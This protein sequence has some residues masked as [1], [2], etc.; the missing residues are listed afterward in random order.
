MLQ[1]ISLDRN[2]SLAELSCWNWGVT[3]LSLD[4]YLEV[5][6]QYKEFKCHI[7]CLGRIE[8]WVK[9]PKEHTISTKK[10][11]I[12]NTLLWGN[13][14]ATVNHSTKLIWLFSFFSFYTGQRPEKVIRGSNQL[15]KQLKGPSCPFL[16]GD[17]IS[18]SQCPNRPFV[19]MNK[20][21]FPT[22]LMWP[23]Q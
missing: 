18:L 8:A 17:M 6:R 4:E 19:F 12:M 3:S 13:N 9:T 22:G 16:L 2:A 5:N 15:W 1:G 14:T 23:L 20:V 21:L 11:L 10:G 7:M